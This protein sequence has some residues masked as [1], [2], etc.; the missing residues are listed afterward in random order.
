MSTLFIRL[1]AKATFDLTTPM[2]MPDCR[3]ALVSE[4]NRIERQ[5]IA[6]LSDLAAQIAA[7]ARVVLI[8]AAADVSL[9][10][11]QVPPMSDSRLKMALPNLVEDQLLDDPLDC[12]IV[13]GRRRAVKLSRNDQ[14]PVDNV[15]DNLRLIAVVQRE[16]LLLIVKTLRALGAGN[17]H[18]F[19][20]QLCLCLAD[21]KLMVAAVTDHG[22]VIE[23]ALRMA[24]EEGIGWLLSP[25]TGQSSEQ[26]ILDSL[27]A[28][29]AQ[30]QVLLYVPEASLL[31]F[32]ERGDTQVTI[33]LDDWSHWI[34]GAQQLMREG[35]IDLMGGLTAS[36]AGTEF[37]WR[38][39]RW[40]I[41]LAAALLMVNVVSL[42]VDWWRM[43]REAS[44]L[45]AGM[46]QSYRAAY[47]KETVIL[48]PIAQMQQKIALAESNNGR[49][50]HDDFLLLLAGFGETW[51]A[52][53][54]SVE[55]KAIGALEYRDHHLLVHWKN[56]QNADAAEAPFKRA[57]DAKLLTLTKPVDGVW[58]IGS[59]Q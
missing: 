13:T 3:Y 27:T 41:A 14:H 52:L 8:L 46:L 24:G 6:P 49:F 26:T 55:T 19:P 17:L 9:L 51:A 15:P 35:G 39:W 21:P 10:R 45:R 7:A 22:G 56:I 43:R 53:P 29:L 2:M 25:V 18:V 11:M 48:D 59:R 5:G 42:Q 37:R 4:Q 12:V 50:S 20:A 30:Q 23:V 31:A 44:S 34:A 33:A 36:A 40:P 1:P 16:W 57:L 38:R 28:I 54:Q 47:P 32:R 58:Q